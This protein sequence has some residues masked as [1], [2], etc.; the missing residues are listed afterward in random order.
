MKARGGWE[1][2]RVGARDG[3]EFGGTF[4]QKLRPWKRIKP[5]YKPSTRSLKV[6]RKLCMWSWAKSRFAMQRKTMLAPACMKQVA[7]T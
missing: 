3:R 4:G 2:G 5:R 7:L 1:Q 6:F